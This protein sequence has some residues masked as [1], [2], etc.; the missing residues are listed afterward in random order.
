SLF[1]PLEALFLKDGKRIVYLKKGSSYKPCF[2]EIGRENDNFIII[3]KGLKEG[4]V[5]AL[6]EPL[7]S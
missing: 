1:I 7:E 3:S 5:V 2:V 6:T 4:D